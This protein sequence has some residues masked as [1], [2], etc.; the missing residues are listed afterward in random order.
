MSQLSFDD[1]ML[2]EFREKEKRLPWFL[3]VSSAALLKF[4]GEDASHPG[5]DFHKHYPTNL[6]KGSTGFI[7]GSGPGL[8]NTGFNTG[9]KSCLVK[10][11]DLVPLKVTEF[12][13]EEKEMKWPEDFTVVEVVSN[14][15]MEVIDEGWLTA[16]LPDRCF[17][18]DRLPSGEFLKVGR[19]HD[20]RTNHFKGFEPKR[21][22]VWKDEA[23]GK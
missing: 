23:A 22:L 12:T 6:E 20:L 11:M 4:T 7:T 10:Y 5:P 8:F 14:N 16:L 21:M 17:I 13:K 15:T 18:K 19:W 3:Q 9:R 2:K 1:L